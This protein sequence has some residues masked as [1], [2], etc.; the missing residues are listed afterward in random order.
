MGEFWHESWP[1]Q[2]AAK[3]VGFEAPQRSLTPWRYEK[4]SD[5]K[6]KKKAL[7]GGGEGK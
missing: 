7:L 4:R 5:V 6:R 1:W 2:E 3:H